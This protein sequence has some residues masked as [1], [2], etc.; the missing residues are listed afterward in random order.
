MYFLAITQIVVWSINLVLDYFIIKKSK[1]S[2]NNSYIEY[3]KTLKK[4]DNETYVKVMRKK[5]LERVIL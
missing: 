4:Y 2:L 5:K 3:Y 1:K